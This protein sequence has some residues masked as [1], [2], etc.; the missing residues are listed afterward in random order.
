MRQKS[1]YITKIDSEKLM[2]LLFDAESTIY[3]GSSYLKALKEELNRAI[4]VESQQIPPEVIT[5]NSTV[6]LVDVETGENMEYTL[7]FPEDA[8][9][10]RGKISVLAPI[11]TG[12]LG[13]RVG[14]VFEW[15]T[16][17]GKRVIRVERILF[18]P[19]EHGEY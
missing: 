16:P 4:I 7:V 13:F 15:D 12:M 17:D 3:R 5:M 2:D 18:Q 9:I 11:G 6:S 1:I 8:D 10:T 14:D 19:E